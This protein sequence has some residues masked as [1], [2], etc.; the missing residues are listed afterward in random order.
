MKYDHSKG[1][2]VQKRGQTAKKIFLN[3]EAEYDSALERIRE[4][5]Y[6]QTVK[7]VLTLHNPDFCALQSPFRNTLTRSS[8]TYIFSS[9]FPY[10]FRRHEAQ[11]KLSKK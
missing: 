5:L 10:H 2:G 3:R 11:A 1:K 8:I 9:F 7:E 4:E 6:G